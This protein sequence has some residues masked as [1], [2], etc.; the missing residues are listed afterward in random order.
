MK[1]N[2]IIL[3][4][5]I[6]FLLFVLLQTNYL[7][8]QLCS[9]GST[10][11]ALFKFLKSATLISCAVFPIAVIISFL[12]SEIQASWKKFTSI[13]LLSYLTAIVLAPNSGADFIKLEKGTVAIL[14]T[15]LFL[16]I[17]LILIAYKSYKL[18]GR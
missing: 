13:Y 5:F 12:K 8:H 18:R 6:V 15:F 14:L 1:K 7:T 11:S 10:C 17:S 2:Q 4:S 3:V 16:L 9:V